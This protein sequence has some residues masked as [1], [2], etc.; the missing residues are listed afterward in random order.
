VIKKICV[1]G[2]G[3]AGNIF[4]LMLKK[5]FPNCQV[6]K[7]GS[8]DIGIVGVGEGSTEHWKMFMG[9]VDIP[10]AEMIVEASA[11]H[12]LGIRF[13]GWTNHTPDYFHS[14]SSNDRLN[15]FGLMDV[16][17]GIHE[18]GKLLTN[19]ISYRGLVEHSLHADNPHNRTNQF[20]FDTFKLNAYFDSLCFRRNIKVI[21]ATVLDIN[22]DPENGNI[23]SLVLDDGSTIDADFFI[24]ATGFKRLLMTKID[25][26]KWKSYSEYLPMDRA[27]A[28]PS[29][30]PE[31]KKIN[32]FTRAVAK[33]SGW[34]WEIPT[35]ERRGNG[36]V[37]CSQFID[38]EGAVKEA[39][40]QVGFEVEPLRSFSINPGCLENQWVKNVISAGLCSSFVE[41]L[42]ATSI[43]STIQQAI[44]AVRNLAAWDG[45]PVLSKNYNKQMD[46]MMENLVSMISLHYISDRTDTEFWRY[47]QTLPRPEYLVNLLELWAV[48]PPVD[49]DIPKSQYELFHEPH[50]WHVAQ[51]Q[52]LISKEGSSRI[53]DMLG[54][55]ESVNKKIWDT[56]V[57]QTAGGTVDHLEALLSLRG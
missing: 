16:Y 46:T 54:V 50:F 45:N 18:R 43:G 29:P 41:P 52:G 28:F 51:G 5:A 24:D 6:T 22:L 57:E 10:L 4:A 27:I 49:G 14:I 21:E 19:S 42:E 30:L 1:V 20:H 13:E 2:S 56:K 38:E 47:A 37:Y 15:N 9:L 36:Y 7:I 11:T 32:P 53:I 48:R 23:E 25:A 26:N 40:G 39:S 44:A 8:N 34:M 12:K 33:S 35:Q 17:C 3:T 55:R 31:N